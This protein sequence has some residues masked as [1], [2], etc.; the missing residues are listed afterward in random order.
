MA[1]LT[2]EDESGGLPDASGFPHPLSGSESCRSLPGKALTPEQR[3]D[4]AI[5]TEAAALI[6]RSQ[7]HELR[8]RFV[9]VRPLQSCSGKHPRFQ[10]CIR[11]HRGLVCSVCRSRSRRTACS[12]ITGCRLHGIATELGSPEEIGRK[13][14]ERALRR[15]GARKIP[16]CQV[17]VDFRSA[18]R[19]IA[20]E[21][22]V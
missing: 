7:H 5:R 10:R 22:S 9:R 13:A 6:D 16:T 21:S 2:S 3:I 14:A 17:P 4:L 20:R 12:A 1:R 19:A 18:D 11:R 15:L 8:R